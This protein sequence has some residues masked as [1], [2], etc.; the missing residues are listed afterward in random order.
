MGRYSAGSRANRAAAAAA[1]RGG[2]GVL[3]VG[4]YSKEGILVT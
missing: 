2:G 1:G 4:F 3:S